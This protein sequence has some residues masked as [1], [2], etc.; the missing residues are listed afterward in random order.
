[1]KGGIFVTGGRGFIGQR[2]L[3]R[4]ASLGAGPIYCLT[5][6]DEAFPASVPGTRLIVGDVADTHAYRHVLDDCRMVL[7]LAAATGAARPREFMAVNARG[8]AALLA[9]SRD[10]GIETFVHVSSVAAAVRDTRHYPYAR[11]KALAEEAVRGSGLSFVIVRPT[12]VVGAGG[13]AW[14]SF[15]R[16]ARSSVIVLPGGGLAPVDPVFVDDVVDCLLSVVRGEVPLNETFT[17]GGPERLTFADLLRAVYRHRHAALPIIIPVPIG[18][19]VRSLA[20]L[21]RLGVTRLPVT[22]GQLT[23][24][25]V[26]ATTDSARSFPR[27]SAGMTGVAEML[28]LSLDGQAAGRHAAPSPARECDVFTRYLLGVPPTPGVTAKYADAHVVMPALASG[29]ATAFDDWLLRIASAHPRL[30][31]LC[32]AYASAFYRRAY[33]RQKLVVL[34][35]ILETSAATAASFD[36]EVSRHQA[37][38]VLRLAARMIAALLCT[39]LG[40][41]MLSP[42]R[43]VLRRARAGRGH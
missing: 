29:P 35:A 43:L 2:L 30:T 39:A 28:R 42:A 33:L 1:M 32:D 8:T 13:G 24:L 7:H 9:S 31:R 10:A 25:R 23:A 4:L 36:A 18:P 34:L 5:R 11:S 26:G 40:V 14:E 12:I 27:A 22:A 17:I 19:L 6:R 3:P 21:E 38:G 16:L 20:L 37:I 15:I 41:L